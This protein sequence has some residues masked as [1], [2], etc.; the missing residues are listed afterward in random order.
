MARIIS[1]VWSQIR[2]SIAGT[3]YLSNQFHQIVARHR[4]N[5]VQPNTNYQA[6]VRTALNAASTLWKSITDEQRAD[7]DAYS[8]TCFW[9]GPLGTYT[10]PGRQMFIATHSMRLYLISRGV[11]FIGSSLLAPTIAGFLGIDSVQASTPPSLPGTG[12]K[13]TAGNPNITTIVVWANRSIAYHPSRLRFKGPWDVRWLGKID[14]TTLST[15]VIDFLGLSLGSRYFA[16]VR[17]ISKTGPFKITASTI[18]NALATVMAPGKGS[19]AD[20]LI[21]EPY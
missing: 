14:V 13:I 3:T 17:A 20:K 1:P 5:P 11:I 19:K 16:I 8:A 9:P 10:I 7:W 21:N 12:I 6:A 4:T 2:G 18:V 15:G